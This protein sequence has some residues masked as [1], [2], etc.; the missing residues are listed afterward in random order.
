[1]GAKQST[2]QAGVRRTFSAEEKCKAVLS[3]WAER[4]KPA[5]VCRELSIKWVILSLWQNR[6]LEGMLQALEPRVALQRGP[7]LSPRLQT[8]LQKRIQKAGSQG[9]CGKLEERLAKIQQERTEKTS[10]VSRKPA[11]KKK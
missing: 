5:E 11:T 2:K 9:T 3:I 8:L 4:R 10:E 1:M 7:A 6:A